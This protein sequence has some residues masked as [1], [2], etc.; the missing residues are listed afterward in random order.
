[1]AVSIEVRFRSLHMLCPGVQDVA[2]TFAR[3]FNKSAWTS[4][5]ASIYQVDQQAQT[6]SRP[7]AGIGL[8][9]R[10]EASFKEQVVIILSKILSSLIID[11]TL[12][13]EVGRRQTGRPI[14]F[15]IFWGPWSSVPWGCC[16]QKTWR[17]WSELWKKKR[18]LQHPSVLQMHSRYVNDCP[19][20]IPKK[21]DCKVDI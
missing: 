10:I 18:C 9:I 16:N 15:C 8:V 14:Y 2:R 3:A 21:S 12:S 6:T 5:R 13:Y 4:C 19:V 17:L 20:A 1:M 11:E 7:K